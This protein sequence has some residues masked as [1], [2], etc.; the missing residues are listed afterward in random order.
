MKQDFDKLEQVFNSVKDA[1]CDKNRHE[2]W[3]IDMSDSQILNV[4]DLLAGNIVELYGIYA[5]SKDEKVQ[6]MT[7]TLYDLYESLKNDIKRDLLS[8]DATKINLFKD[9]V[10]KREDMEWEVYKIRQKHDMIA[11]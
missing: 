5:I 6:N 4:F 10:G 11:K 9:I 7:N 3:F 1:V 8:K 2:H